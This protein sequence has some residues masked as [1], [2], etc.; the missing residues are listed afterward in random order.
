MMDTAEIVYI[1][2]LALLK[3]CCFS[4]W[5]IGFQCLFLPTYVL[6]QWVQMLKHGKF[7]NLPIS[8]LFKYPDVENAY[9]LLLHR[10]IIKHSDLVRHWSP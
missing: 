2:S 9:I 7:L 6:I 4:L 5:C 10:Y 3:V 8:A 1:S